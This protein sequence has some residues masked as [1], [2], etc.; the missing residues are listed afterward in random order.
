MQADSQVIK[1]LEL[2]REEKRLVKKELDELEQ[3]YNELVL[4]KQKEE[5]QKKAYRQKRDEMTERLEKIQKK[6]KKHKR[7]FDLL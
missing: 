6:I 3:E 4:K 7:E 1:N 2:L 5:G